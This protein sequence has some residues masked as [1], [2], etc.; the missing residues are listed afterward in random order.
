M[1]TFRP[2]RCIEK[3]GC[4]LSIPRPYVSMVLTSFPATTQCRVWPR[5]SG[6][7]GSRYHNPFL[8]PYLTKPTSPVTWKPPDSGRVAPWS[9]M[10]RLDV[11]DLDSHICGITPAGRTCRIRG[12]SGQPDGLFTF[13]GCASNH[14]TVSPALRNSRSKHLV[15]RRRCAGYPITRPPSAI[16]RLHYEPHQMRDGLWVGPV[17]TYS[18]HL[19][20]MGRYYISSGFRRCSVGWW[21]ILLAVH[22]RWRFAFVQPSAKPEY[23]R[24]YIGPLEVEWSIS[25]PTTPSA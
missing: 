4:S 1:W 7:L 2:K 22:R 25:C 21:H 15:I 8:D 18:E 11:S 20:R 17:L 23:R 24:L 16:E 19:M 3:T 9:I 13:E 12:R 10:Y 6:L 14:F 5:G